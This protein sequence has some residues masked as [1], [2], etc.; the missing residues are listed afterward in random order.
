MPFHSLLDKVDK[1]SQFYEQVATLLRPLLLLLVRVQVAV[2]FLRSGIVKIEDFPG[3]V[4]LFQTEYGVPILPPLL[5]ALMA[6][7]FELGSSLLLI[8]GLASR[9]AALPLI[10]MTGVIELT[11]DRANP[12]HLVWVTLLLTIVCFGAG[13]LSVDGFLLARSRRQPLCI[14]RWIGERTKH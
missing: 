6:T 3:T 13:C 14:F 9:L 2:V 10:G 1:S 12:E 8:L 4:F 5:A 11:Y 7:T